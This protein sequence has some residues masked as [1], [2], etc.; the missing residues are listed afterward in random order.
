MPD[1]CCT[2]K[3]VLR[4]GRLRLA[5]GSATTAVERNHDVCDQWE[6]SFPI[7]A[8]FTSEGPRCIDCVSVKSVRAKALAFFQ[9]RLTNAPIPNVSSSDCVL[10]PKFF[11]KRA[12]C[13]SV[14]VLKD[15]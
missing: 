14:G 11:S 15:A 2:H 13:L 5:A 1:G 9:A 12:K 7:R 4:T 8:V 3:W 6:T 10:R